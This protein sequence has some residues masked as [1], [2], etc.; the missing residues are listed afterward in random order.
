MIHR[1]TYGLWNAKDGREVFARVAPRLERAHRAERDRLEA[2]RRQREAEEAA[3]I[4]MRRRLR[5][6]VQHL[7]HLVAHRE[8]QLARGGKPSKP[9]NGRYLD[10]RAAKLRSAQEELERALRKAREAGAV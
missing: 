8:M 9:R 2:A 3:A 6:R 1:T 4:A 5:E 7:E 10:Y